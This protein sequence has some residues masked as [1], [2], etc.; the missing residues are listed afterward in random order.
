MRVLVTGAGGMVGR[1]LVQYCESLGD[2]V[3][4]CDHAALEIA[5]PLAVMET[6]ERERPETVI[7]CAARTDVDGCER[8]PQ[9]A[10]NANARGP[11]NLAMGSRR[12]GAS[13][14]TISTDFVFDGAKEGF[15]TQRDDPHP[16]SHYGRSKLD[17]ERRA[18]KACAR[19]IIVRS[20]WIF[21]P[22]GRNFLSRV[23]ELTRAGQPLKAIRDAYGTPTSARDLAARLR[24]LVRLDLPGIYHVVNSGEGASFEEF[25]R[26]ALDLAGLD[27]GT[28]ES[29]SMDSLNRPAPRP[30]NSRLRCLLSPALGLKPL[31]DWQDALSDFLAGR[32]WPHGA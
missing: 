24:E 9:S 21:G 6:L 26:A 18:Q 19:T 28:L 22:G 1:A 10:Y 7:N 29:V 14:L 17:G 4:A 3:L 15:Y 30:R 8:D 2:D 23:V 13:F 16:E 27:T 32:V 12:V 20:G 31:P 5:D 25:A 11:E